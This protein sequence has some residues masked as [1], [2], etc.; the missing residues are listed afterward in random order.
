MISVLKEN[1][2]FGGS[3]NMPSVALMNVLRTPQLNFS[4]SFESED[5]KENHSRAQHGFSPS[6]DQF[7]EKFKLEEEKINSFI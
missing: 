5:Y 1:F 2:E 6:E 4:E 7:S 3:F